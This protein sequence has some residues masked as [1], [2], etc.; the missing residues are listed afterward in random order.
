MAKP[1]ARFDFE[2]ATQV[3]K[4]LVN[5]M[6]PWLRLSFIRSWVFWA[7]MT[8]GISGGLVYLALGLLLN[9]KAVPNCPEI[10][11]P[12]SSPSLRVYC[13]QLAASKQNLKDLVAALNLVKDIAPNDPTRSYIDSNVQ[14]WSLSIL[15]L[16]EASYQEGNYDEAVNAAKQV[17]SN[18]PA[19]KIVSRRLGQWQETWNKGVALDRE[20][21]ALL[22]SSKWVNAYSVAVKL[23]RLNNR[24]WAT[25]KYQELADL[26]QVAKADSSKLDEARQLVKVTSVA[27]LLKAVEIANKVDPKSFAHTEAQTLIGNASV[28][29]LTLARAKFDKNDWNGALEIANKT[30]SATQT[31]TELQDLIGLSQAQINAKTGTISE[32][33][34]AISLI[35]GIKPESSLYQKAQQSSGLWQLEI[36]DLA[37]LQHARSVAS[38]ATVADLQLAINEVKGIPT[39]NPRGKEAA[40]VAS[41]WSKQIETVQDAPYMQ[42]A[43]TLAADNTVKGVQ[44]AIVQLNQIR[45]GRA[46][47]PQ[48]RQKI[49]QWTAEIQR[50]EDTP[51]LAQAESLATSGDLRA[52]I[53]MAQK[54]GAGRAISAQSQ[55][56]VSDW[57][58]QLQA[59]ANLANAQRV[60]GNGTPE[61][62]RSAIQSAARVPKSSN[63]RSQARLSMDNW[64]SQ[65]LEIAQSTATSDLSRAISIA[66]S[67][68]ANTSAYSSAQSYIQQWQQQLNP[69]PTPTE[70]PA[71][72]DNGLLN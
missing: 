55:E 11:V 29:M 67:I 2:Q 35:Q 33:E 22:N 17:P 24:Y 38:T 43:D 48:A 61:S 45:P 60:A 69:T 63:L 21:R 30:P 13:G 34:T 44:K 23:T 54:I 3:T 1:S 37:A 52:A 4:Q 28:Q 31:K 65:M 66:Q 57:Q 15:R 7:I 12:M 47:Y 40:S 68:P 58:A 62:L 72:E 70:S 20:T 26:V 5:Q 10:F 27:S 59:S 18:V 53:T 42:A 64:G 16:A 50:A 56:R 19:Y 49:Q 32:L 8:L 36:Q 6:P 14:R 41:E 39:S 51:I 9:P 25:T 46:L 71:T